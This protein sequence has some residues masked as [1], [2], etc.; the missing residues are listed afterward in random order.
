[1]ADQVLIS[2]SLFKDM[3]DALIVANEVLEKHRLAGTDQNPQGV[4]DLVGSAALRSRNAAKIMKRCPTCGREVPT[5]FEHVD[6]DCETWGDR[7]TPEDDAAEAAYKA[8]SAA[9]QKEG[10]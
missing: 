3:R 7:G 1:M 4:R 8:K 5:I 9:Q 2:L 6:V 10:E